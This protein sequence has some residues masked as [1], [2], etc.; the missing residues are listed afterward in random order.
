[1]NQSD[2]ADRDTHMRHA[3]VEGLLRADDIIAAYD[4]VNPV[5]EFWNRIQKFNRN[6]SEC[7]LFVTHLPPLHR[8]QATRLEHIQHPS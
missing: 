4:A 6:W 2:V 3:V 1:M 7:L 5:L 8:H